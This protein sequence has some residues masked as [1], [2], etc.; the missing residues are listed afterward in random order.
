MVWGDPDVVH[1]HVDACLVHNSM[2]ATMRNRQASGNQSH[3]T[4]TLELDVDVE[5]DAEVNVDLDGPRDTDD[6]WEETTTPEGHIGLRLR[7]GGVGS[8]S[9]GAAQRLGFVVGS[10]GS[11][12]LGRRGIGGVNND[13]S[14]M[15]MDVDVDVDGD[16]EGAFGTVQFGEEDVIRLTAAGNGGQG[17]GEEADVDVDGEGEVETEVESERPE[18]KLSPL[19][20]AERELSRAKIAGDAQATIRA[21]ETLLQLRSFPRP[22]APSAPSTAMPS[23]A[24]TN[25]S[26]C[27]I[28]LDTYIEPT[29]ST[30]CWHV[31]C[32]ECWLRCLGSTKLC[33]ICMRITGVGELRRV[34]I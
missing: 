25:Q 29:V 7:L 4:S 24:T 27:R 1:A 34:Y 28:C 18:K 10:S 17:G 11:G 19:Q 13:D 15:D 5:E 8:A 3:S 31:C 30:G 23:S 9:R 14:E 20:Q 32:K 21:L 22:N 16:D 2:V 33:P 12:S 6:L 26:T